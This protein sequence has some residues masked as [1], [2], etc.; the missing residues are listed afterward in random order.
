MFTLSK[1]TRGHF[2]GPF[3]SLCP[4]SSAPTGTGVPISHR[5]VSTIESTTLQTSS[6][7]YEYYLKMT[8]QNASASI[9][10]TYSLVV[11]HKKSMVNLTM[12]TVDIMSSTVATHA[13]DQTLGTGVLSKS[14]LVLLNDYL[15]NHSLLSPITS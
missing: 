15:Q 6:L 9:A 14:T 11:G 10:T 4:Q 8:F 3:F 13:S 7:K 5:S 2:G 12:K 1:Y